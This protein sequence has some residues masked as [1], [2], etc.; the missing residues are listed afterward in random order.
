[1]PGASAL[2]ASPT[3]RSSDLAALGGEGAAP[4]A[5]PHPGGE[6][7]AGVAR[8][9]RLDLGPAHAPPLADHGVVGVVAGRDQVL[10]EEPVG[11]LL[12]S[13]EHTSELQSRENL[14][15]R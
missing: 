12:R 13:E 6:G 8:A 1:P 9:G 3:R 15:C 4:A 10:A 14:V 2:P 11:Q 7:A 5:V